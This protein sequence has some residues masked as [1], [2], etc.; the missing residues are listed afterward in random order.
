MQPQESSATDRLNRQLDRL[1]RLKRHREAARAEGYGDW[2]LHDYDRD[3]NNQVAAIR[4]LL[5]INPDLLHVILERV[6]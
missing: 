1:A 6:S 5:A 4:Q 3:I 2:I